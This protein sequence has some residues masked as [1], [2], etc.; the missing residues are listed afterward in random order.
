[1]TLC[2]EDSLQSQDAQAKSNEIMRCNYVVI[3]PREDESRFDSWAK[4]EERLKAYWIEEEW[5]NT[6]EYAPRLEYDAPYKFAFRRWRARA[7]FYNA[8]RVKQEVDV[9]QRQADFERAVHCFMDYFGGPAR[10]LGE[11]LKVASN[12][13]TVVSMCRLFPRVFRLDNC[14]C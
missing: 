5:R 11:S 14:P 6:G 3:C 2:A 8:L 9:S 7:E 12:E 10:G 4:V 13:E 1:M